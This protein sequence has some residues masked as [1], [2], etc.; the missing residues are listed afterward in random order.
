MKQFPQHSLR[1]IT[2]AF[3]FQ[4][5][6]VATRYQL[7]VQQACDNEGV[8][9]NGEPGHMIKGLQEALIQV[10]KHTPLDLFKLQDQQDVPF[11]SDVNEMLN[12]LVHTGRFKEGWLPSFA[13]KPS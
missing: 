4:A 12:R 3:D 1:P 11:C 13:R 8:K 10:N 5:L 6:Q 7:C 9:L 2:L